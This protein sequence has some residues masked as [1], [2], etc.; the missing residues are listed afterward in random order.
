[1]SI[2]SEHYFNLIKE[3]APEKA[4]RLT[5]MRQYIDRTTGSNHFP[6]T[7]PYQ[8]TMGEMQ[9]LLELSK[10]STFEALCLAFDYGRAKGYMAAQNK[11]RTERKK[12]A[13]KE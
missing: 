3:V 11:A 2:Y 10:Q 8:P 5:A 12:E 6:D 7:T 4:K 1:M 13:A 9:S